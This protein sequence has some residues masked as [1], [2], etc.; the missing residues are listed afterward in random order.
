MLTLP[1]KFK[2]DV[3]RNT[4][5]L[6][7]SIRHERSRRLID[8]RNKA[9]LSILYHSACPLRYLLSARLK[10]LVGVIAL[11]VGQQE[12]ELSRQN[13]LRLDNR[14]FLLLNP[15]RKQLEAWLDRLEGIRGQLN[16]DSLIFPG[17]QSAGTVPGNRSLAAKSASAIIRK[18]GTKQKMA[19]A[20]LLNA[21]VIRSAGL[22]Y[23]INE[24]YHPYAAAE[25]AG[26]KSVLP[27]LKRLTD[28]FDAKLDLTE[29]GPVGEPTW[30]P[31][32]GLSRLISKRYIGRV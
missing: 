5:A 19:E 31:A 29:M 30:A 11:K 3:E 27:A 24:G 15:A 26:Y 21:T 32:S 6:R 20:G 7:E 12:Y 8:Y 10:N 4:A 9:I 1:R 13:A 14:T 25:L 22:P 23:L 18:Y 17:F 16:R 2:R 28:R